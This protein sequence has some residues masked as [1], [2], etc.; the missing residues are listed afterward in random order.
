MSLKK[1]RGSL[2]VSAFVALGATAVGCGDNNDGGGGT[3]DAGG[4]GMT[5]GGSDGGGGGGGTYD[6]SGVLITVLGKSA[7]DFIA[8]SHMM[9]LLDPQG[10][11]LDPPITATTNASDG[12]WT[13]KNIPE[14]RPNQSDW[15]HVIG[16]GPKTDGNATYDALVLADRYL[17]G[18]APS[19]GVRISTV[20]TATYAESTGNFKAADD[21]IAIGGQI[22]SVD[23]TGKQVGSVGC[24]EVWV[25]DQP[26]PYKEF[27]QR[28][29]ASSG[30]PTDIEGPS[31]QLQTLTSGKF[32]IGNVP[33]GMH[34]FKVTL[35]HGATFIGEPLTINVPFSRTDATS[36]LKNF[37][38]LIGITIKGPNPTPADCVDPV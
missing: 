17:Y 37:L 35:D 6:Q 20:G 26:S 18:S 22:Y 10:M 7:A 3:P 11:P 8:Q 32:L 5:G 19:L 34:T 36:D 33:K 21:K 23:D 24:A 2:L 38:V 15:V 13:F 27:D 28:Y 12:S 25:D 14:G 16:V 29:V 31:A 1:M 4:G 9:E 30:L